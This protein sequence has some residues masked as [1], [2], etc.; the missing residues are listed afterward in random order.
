MS[1]IKL[2]FL[3]LIFIFMIMTEWQI[4]FNLH[5]KLKQNKFKK[6]LCQYSE[7]K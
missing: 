3:S 7:Q 6:P 4:K 1:V 5:A 2:I